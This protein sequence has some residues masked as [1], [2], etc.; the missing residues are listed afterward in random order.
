MQASN[1]K[2]NITT[3]PDLVGGEV[4]CWNLNLGCNLIASRLCIRCNSLHI[5]IRLVAV[6]IGARVLF[7]TITSVYM[8]AM[9]PT[10]VTRPMPWTTPTIY[11]DVVLL[12]MITNFTA[13]MIVYTIF[14][15]IGNIGVRYFI[16]L[17]VTSHI[18]VWHSIQQVPYTTYHVNQIYLIRCFK[19]FTHNNDIQ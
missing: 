2:V 5:H 11:V 4:S 10:V 17:N 1:K 9:I 16:N 19:P 15:Y 3:T 12:M 7:F 8:T 14:L 6:T 18:L 13:S